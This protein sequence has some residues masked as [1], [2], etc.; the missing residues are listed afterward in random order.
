M[1]DTVY[2]DFNVQLSSAYIYIHMYIYVCIIYLFLSLI[3]FSFLTEFIGMTLV[4]TSFRFRVNGSVRHR[5]YTVLCVHHPKSSLLPSPFV[6]QHPPPTTPPQPPNNHHILVH[7]HEFCFFL[8]LLCSFLTY[9][10][11]IQKMSACSL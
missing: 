10:G 3:N 7:L 9:L 8:F 11:P 6:P 4:N 2:S 5:L 1:Y